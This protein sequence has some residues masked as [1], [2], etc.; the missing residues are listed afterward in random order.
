MAVYD[1]DEIVNRNTPEDIK[2]EKVDGI[3]DLIPMWVADMDFRSPKEVID[4]LVS[5]SKNG[6]F[7]YS[8]ADATYDKAVTGWFKKRYGWDVDPKTIL[9]LPGVV[10]GVSFSIRA[11]TELND[12]V[13]IFITKPASGTEKPRK[14]RYRVR[15][16]ADRK[17]VV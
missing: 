17:S 14:V 10:L 5:V 15:Q 3:D 9:K 7:G 11:L 4:S 2:Y 8:E 1:F 12:S 16:N 6:V 13:L